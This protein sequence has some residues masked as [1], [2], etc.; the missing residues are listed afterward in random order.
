[1][2]SGRSSRKR[3]AAW[4]ATLVECAGNPI[5]TMPQYCSGIDTNV[6][7]SPISTQKTQ[8]I[9][10]SMRSDRGIVGVTHADVA[11]VDRIVFE[12]SKQARSVARQVGV[13]Q[14]AHELLWRRGRDKSLVLNKFVGKRDGSSNVF[15][16]D[17]VLPDDLIKADTVGD[18]CEDSSDGHTSALNHRL[19]VMNLG[20]DLNSIV[21]RGNCSTQQARRHE[22]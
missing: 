13:D 10:L 11:Y 2:M 5:T 17:L 20:I 8:L 15:S 7:E 1:M 6:R 16:S 22:G 14:K 4:I 12:R 3:I 18:F 9:R 21:H 19:P